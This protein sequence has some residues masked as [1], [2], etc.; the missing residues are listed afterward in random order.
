MLEA[1]TGLT[2]NKGATEVITEHILSASDI[3]SD[4]QDIYFIL[5]EP[6]S[7]LG[8]FMLITE[9]P[10]GDLDGWLERTDGRWE[11]DVTEFSQTNIVNKEVN[12][13]GHS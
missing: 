5:E 8:K 9:E 11:S 2:I 3:D 13:G 6:Y 10:T 1:N 4:L 12:T 7:T